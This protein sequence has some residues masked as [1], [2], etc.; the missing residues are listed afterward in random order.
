MHAK[1]YHTAA[2]SDLPYV[3]GVPRTGDK[4]EKPCNP[5]ALHSLQIPNPDK[6]KIMAAF[7]LRKSLW[8]RI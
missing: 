5:G 7:T 4:A 1:G 6:R 2:H 3:A 8:R